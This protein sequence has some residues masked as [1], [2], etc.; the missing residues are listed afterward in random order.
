MKT[1]LKK[2]NLWIVFNL[3]L[4]VRAQA[5]DTILTV[6]T[7]K[8]SDGNGIIVDD[9][10][11]H[12]NKSTNGVYRGGELLQGNLSHDNGG[13]GMH[14]YAS[15]NIDFINNTVCNNS[16]VVDYG[17]LSVTACGHVRVLNNILVAKKDKPL[18]RVNGAFHDV[19]LSH[20]LFWGGNGDTVAGENTIKADPHFK[21]TTKS[22]FDLNEKSPARDAGGS[23]EISLTKDLAGKL[24]AK[25]ELDLGALAR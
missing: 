1:M 18:N 20:N 6:T 16:N 13:S 2:M 10:R 7:G 5:V 24:R 23:W 9:T 4:A 15:D 14:C 19:L 21:E 8:P 17:E 12:Q 22:D 25:D 11:N 3:L